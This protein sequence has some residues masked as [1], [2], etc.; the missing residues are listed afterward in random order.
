MV[1]RI[2]MERGKK[3]ERG[4]TRRQILK[5]FSL[6]MAGA[7]VANVVAGGLLSSFFRSRRRSVPD[8]PE[9]SIFAPSRDRYKNI[10]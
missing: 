9:D 2:A 4:Y 5:R 10:S 6:G 8:F 1:R 3:S 7:A